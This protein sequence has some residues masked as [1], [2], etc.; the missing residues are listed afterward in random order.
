VVAPESLHRCINGGNARLC[1]SDRRFIFEPPVSCV[2][3][4]ITLYRAR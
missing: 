1:R 2:S 3:L 4:W